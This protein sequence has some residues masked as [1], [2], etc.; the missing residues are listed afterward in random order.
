[1]EKLIKVNIVIEAHEDDTL[2]DIIDA[3]V[4]FVESKGWFL[5]GGFQDIT[6]EENI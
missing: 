2:D 1:M 6:D 4:E 3:L 5:G